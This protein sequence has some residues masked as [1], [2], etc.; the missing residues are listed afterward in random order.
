MKNTKQLFLSLFLLTSLPTLGM[1]RTTKKARTDDGHNTEMTPI[2]NVAA[3]VPFANNLV[4]FASSN[5]GVTFGARKTKDGLQQFFGLVYQNR[6]GD[7]KRLIF[8]MQ[9][10]YEYRSHILN[11]SF[12]KEASL[13]MRLLTLREAQDW[14]HA[15]QNHLVAYPPRVPLLPGTGDTPAVLNIN[16]LQE[17]ARIKYFRYHARRKMWE[18]NRLMYIGRTERGSAFHGALRE[19]VRM[20]AWHVTELEAQNML[21]QAQPDAELHF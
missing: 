14:D 19:I 12:L 16:S 9:H 21:L 1:E 11:D 10:L 15:I 5:N 8:P 18:K 6:T 3:I 4:I 13:S 7:Y 17:G 20:I 2:E